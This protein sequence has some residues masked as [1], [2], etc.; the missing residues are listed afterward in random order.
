MAKTLEQI[1]LESLVCDC[2]SLEELYVLWQTMQT[3][4]ADGTDTC[5]PEIDKRSFHVDGMISPEKFSGVL[6][7]LKE[8]SLKKYI[9]KGLNF[10]VITD[11]RKEYR[12]YKGGFRNEAGYVA[13]MQRVLLGEEGQKLTDKQVMDTLGIIYVNK[14]GGRELTDHIW[15][16]YGNEYI[17]FIKRQIQLI[18]PSVIICGGEDI[19]RLVV[20]EVFHNKKS[21]R[22]KGEH[23]VWK[24]VVKD[25]RFMA[26][27]NYRHTEKPEKAAVTVVNMWNPAYRMNKAQYL[28]PEEYLEEFK[29]RI[30]GLRK[31]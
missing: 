19:F 6:Y 18:H 20:K 10:P 14:R 28:S 13:G 21:I 22:N 3:M 2:C 15:L 16:N 11:I 25:Y 27:K 31:L 12:K 8:P 29:T 23:M 26:D 1:V 5:C 24:D 7:I 17:E 4:D 30:S 9:Q